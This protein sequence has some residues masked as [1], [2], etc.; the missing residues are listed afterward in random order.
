M[1]V[2]MWLA[3][4]GLSAFRMAL[5]IPLG[6]DGKMVLCAMARCFWDI[7]LC[8]ARDHEIIVVYLMSHLLPLTAFLTASCSPVISWTSISTS[9][10]IRPASKFTLNRSMTTCIDP[11]GS[12]SRKTA[13]VCG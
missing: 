5:G 3:F 10:G 4:V 11:P 9:L 2:F 7:C 13:C 12:S 6:M 1:G 8:K